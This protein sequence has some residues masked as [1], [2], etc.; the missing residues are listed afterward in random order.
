MPKSAKTQR[1]CLGCRQVF[2]QDELVRYVASPQHE[3]LV[4]YRG[5]LPGRGAY[6]C[7]DRE[8]V[9]LA[10][11]R[12][13]FGRALRSDFAPFEA[14]NL[15]A[16]LAVQVEAKVLSLV[17]MARKSGKIISGGQMVLKALSGGGIAVVLLAQDVSNGIGEKVRGKAEATGTPWLYLAE[18]GQL[19]QLLGKAERSVVG[20]G[21]GALAESLKVEL[22]RLKKIV[23]ES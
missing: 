16:A 15:M 4:D 6:T 1:T 5:R 8:C 9:T 14:D 11:K 2:G 21:K 22:L 7:L 13:Q 10:V 20:I 17:G 18:K 23:G 3:L 12:R 19:G